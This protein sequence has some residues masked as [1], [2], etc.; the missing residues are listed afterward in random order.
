MSESKVTMQTKIQSIQNDRFWQ[1]ILQASA[2]RQ[3]S[4]EHVNPLNIMF[5][6]EQ[7]SQL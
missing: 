7:A 6:Q 2:T 3:L 5:L 1:V 4:D